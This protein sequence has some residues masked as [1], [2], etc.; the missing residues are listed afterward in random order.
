M[1]LSASGMIC[2]SSLRRIVRLIAKSLSWAIDLSFDFSLEVTEGD[3]DRE[4]KD[5]NQCVVQAAGI[6]HI[7]D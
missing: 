4:E 7:Q 5:Q 2:R 1:V 3:C 6:S